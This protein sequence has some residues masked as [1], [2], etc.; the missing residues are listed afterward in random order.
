MNHDPGTATT[1]RLRDYRAT[2]ESSWLRCRVL[3]FLDTQYF[4]DVATAK[5]PQNPGLELVAIVGDPVAGDSVVGVCD[6]SIDASS[7][8]IETIAVHPDH[9]RRGIGSALV[10][11]VRGRLAQRGVATLDAWTREDLGTLTWYRAAGFELNFRYLHV[12]AS[13]PEEM[14]LATT[15]APGLV[16]RLGHFH[17]DATDELALRARFRRVHACHQFVLDLG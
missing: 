2:D 7:A 9:R 6:V 4:D 15:S 11:A 16:G 5:P 12:Y 3:G 17:A 14:A 1:W 10:T 13:T 8:T